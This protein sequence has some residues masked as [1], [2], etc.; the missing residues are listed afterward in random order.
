MSEPNKDAIEW[1]GRLLRMV[2]TGEISGFVAV[3]PHNEHFEY[4]RVGEYDEVR[5]IG[6]LCVVQQRELETVCDNLEPSDCAP[7]VSVVDEDDDDDR[8]PIW[9]RTTRTNRDRRR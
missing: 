6:Q 3:L 8:A 7:K 2:R 5:M 1:A 4:M 9:L